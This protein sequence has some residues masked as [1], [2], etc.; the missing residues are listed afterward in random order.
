MNGV[1]IKYAQTLI[2]YI[3]WTS[4][5]APVPVA[6][7][8]LVRHKEDLNTWSNLTCQIVLVEIVIVKEQLLQ[9]VFVLMGTASVAFRLNVLV[10]NVV[11]VQV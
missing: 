3:A 6:L 9:P 8:V 11:V 1:L 10:L 5:Q 7:V 2:I 4:L